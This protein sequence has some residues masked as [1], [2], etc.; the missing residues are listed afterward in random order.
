M[1]IK[2]GLIAILL[3]TPSLPLSAQW[4]NLKDRIPRNKDGSPNLTAPAPRRSDHKPDLTGI[5]NP[6]PPKLDTLI[7][8]G[9]G[10]SKS[11]QSAGEDTRAARAS[12]RSCEGLV[13]CSA[14]R[15]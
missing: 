9:P 1:L 11:C 2:T 13:T 5:W 15:A 3:I 8:A 4:P 7:G 6:E 10:W 12:D 14:L